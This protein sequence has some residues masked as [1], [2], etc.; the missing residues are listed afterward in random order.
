MHSFSASGLH[1]IYELAGATAAANTTGLCKCCCSS[2]CP[3]TWF[4]WPLYLFLDFVILL[5]FDHSQACVALSHAVHY[6]VPPPWLFASNQGSQCFFPICF[7][8][9]VA[10]IHPLRSQSNGNLFPTLAQPFVFYLLPWP[11]CRI[12]MQKIY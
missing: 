11:R 7:G 3:S 10:C 2:G 1:D 5:S 12:P 4:A 6:F 9:N 8:V